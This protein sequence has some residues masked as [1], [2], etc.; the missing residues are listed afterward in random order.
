MFCPEVIMYNCR[1]GLDNHAGCS[2]RCVRFLLD[3]AGRAPDNLCPKVVPEHIVGSGRRGWENKR[4]KDYGWPQPE[5][6]E[7]EGAWRHTEEEEKHSLISESYLSFEQAA[8]GRCKFDALVYSLWLGGFLAMCVRRT[9]T[10]SC[11]ASAAP[12]IDLFK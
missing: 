12:Y 8:D 9:F 11:N 10:K 7:Q 3:T 6:D 4:G 1:H 2:L 5:R